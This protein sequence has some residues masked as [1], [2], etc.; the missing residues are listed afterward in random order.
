MNP[1]RL[2]VTSFST[3]NPLGFGL[4]QRDRSPASYEDPE[5]MYEHR[6]S[7]WIEPQG[8]WGAGRVELVQ[9]PTPD[10][11][12]DNIIAYWVPDKPVVAKQPFDFSYLMRWQMASQT[13]TGKGWVLQS[14]RG[15]GP[16]KMP[17]WRDQ[18]RRRLRRPGAAR[19]RARRQARSRSSNSAG[20]AELKERN[21]FRNRVTGAWRM[22]V[23]IKRAD[24][25]KPIEMR[26]YLKTAQDPIT[27]TWS[28]IIPPES[29]KP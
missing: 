11:T 20:N 21:L 26:A 7:V 25:A 23:R 9:I 3:T 18:L 5:A 27:E 24:A 8:D 4:M 10:E 14:R 12:N 17:D 29:E 22:T 6:P 15:H 1:K 2:L 28:Y 19:P 13:P 16:G